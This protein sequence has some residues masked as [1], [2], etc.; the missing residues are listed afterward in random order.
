MKFIVTWNSRPASDPGGNVA[1]AESVVRR[2]ESDSI[3]AGTSGR[4]S[5]GVRLFAVLVALVVWAAAC[6]SGD[7][8]TPSPPDTSAETEDSAP[9]IDPPATDPPVT[10]PPATDPAPD[11]EL[12]P[13]PFVG[14]IDVLAEGSE[15]SGANGMFFDAEDRLWVA[16]VASGLWV[17]DPESGETLERYD[18]SDGVLS[19]DDVT[20][21]ADGS[22]YFTNIVQ[23]SVGKLAPDGTVSD[24]AVLGQGVN[25]I[26]LR[27]EQTLFVGLDFLGDGLWSIDLTGASEPR[28]VVAEPGWIN[29]MDFGPDGALYGPRWQQADVVR[30]DPDSG[31]IIQVASGFESVAAAVKFNSQGELYAVEATPQHVVMIDIET[32]ERELVATYDRA[33]DNLAFDSADRLYISSA[34]DGSIHEV[35]DDG[36]LRTVKEG[37]LNNSSGIS[38]QARDGIDEVTV[39]AGQG[40]LTF[41]GSTGEEIAHL[42]LGFESG[43]LQGSGAGAAIDVDGDV[44]LNADW[45]RPEVEVWDLAAGSVT[46][47]YPVDGG[48]TD[49]IRFQGEIYA[50]QAVNN[51]AIIGEGPP[52]PLFDIAGAN[53]L[54]ATDDDLFVAAAGTGEV[55][56]LVEDGVRLDEPRAVATGLAQP[57]G[58]T[59][60]PDGNL[61]V[62][63]VGTGNVVHIETATGSTTVLAEGLSPVFTLFEGLSV[64]GPNAVAAGSSGIVYVTS[65]LDGNVYRIDVAG[66]LAAADGD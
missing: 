64:W 10:D 16:S 25:S 31:E 66:V 44:L 32:G 61:V 13:E 7:D 49:V 51:V 11:V 28:L 35:L 22:V 58:L 34:E 46:A 12:E 14:P 38:V 43:E 18:V 63:E 60:L 19:P 45:T 23:G 9:P 65:P 20:I 56:Q 53:G 2:P 30:I 21:G 26:T 29:G 37:A 6:S 4:S 36:T 41:D 54:A 42:S 15:I 59:A 24:V 62:V 57:E 48:S 47:V 33:G 52:T 3:V 55:L 50:S 1:A 39:M 5:T 40:L 8:S 17:I 27:D